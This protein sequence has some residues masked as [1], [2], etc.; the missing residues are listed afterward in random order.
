MVQLYSNKGAR[1][2]MPACT[3]GGPAFCNFHLT[4]KSS[5]PSWSLLMSQSNKETDD[6]LPVTHVL[7][8]RNV[9]R[10]EV[11]HKVSGAM[12]RQGPHWDLLPEL[13]R[14]KHPSLPL[15][16]SPYLSMSPHAHVYTHTCT[17]AHMCPAARLCRSWTGRGKWEEPGSPHPSMTL[18]PNGGLRR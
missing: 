6:R 9:L 15:L 17:C 7:R 10:L 18:V 14:S 1:D 16:T 12:L 8:S 11:Y 2:H 4:P 3:P 13:W 5:H